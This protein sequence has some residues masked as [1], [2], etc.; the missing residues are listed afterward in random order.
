[1]SV[2]TVSDNNPNITTKHHNPHLVRYT[3]QLEA[4]RDRGAFIDEATRD[5]LLTNCAW[6]SFWHELRILAQQSHDGS[7]EVSR[8][9]ASA[10]LT[11]RQRRYLLRQLE[12]RGVIVC[13]DMLRQVTVL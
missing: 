1:M 4:A 8:V 5:W 10:F 12:Q 2:Y 7:V 6:W 9:K 3:Q 11:S 13:G